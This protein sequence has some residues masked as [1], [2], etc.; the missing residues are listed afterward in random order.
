MLLYRK[1]FFILNICEI[2]CS[3]KSI[4]LVGRPFCLASIKFGKS[5]TLAKYKFLNII[6]DHSFNS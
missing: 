5:Y 3:R 6:N 2:T 1:T 4:R